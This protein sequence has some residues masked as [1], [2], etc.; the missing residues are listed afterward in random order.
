MRNETEIKQEIR[1]L[2]EIHLKA[3][4]QT[5]KTFLEANINA[6][7]WV[8]KTDETIRGIKK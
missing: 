7:E 5:Y 8:L 6:L 2:K 1:K 3:K 4:N